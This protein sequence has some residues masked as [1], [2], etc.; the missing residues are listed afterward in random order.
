MFLFLFFTFQGLFSRENLN[1]IVKNPTADNKE[2]SPVEFTTDIDIAVYRNGKRE[3]LNPDGEVSVSQLNKF[4][5]KGCSIRMLRP[6]KYSNS[7]WKLLSG[8]EDEF[9]NVVGAN[10]YLTP[11][12]SQGFAPHFD[13]I[14]AF[15]LQ[16]EGS[17]RWKLHSNNDDNSK[18]CTFSSSNFESDDVR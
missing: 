7:M 13:D 10:C 11:P 5:D 4:Y 6:Q 9:Q 18:L 2:A 8:L 16:T 3:T 17:K 14:E 12:N 1:S 15:V